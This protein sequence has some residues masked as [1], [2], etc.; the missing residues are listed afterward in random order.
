VTT[1]AIDNSVALLRFLLTRDMDAYHRLAAEQDPREHRTYAALLTTA[2][3]QATAKRFAQDS[4]SAAIIEFVSEARA[5]IVGP[6]A[7]VPEDAERVIRAALG[8]SDLIDDMDGKAYGRAQVAVLLAI[9]HEN[10]DAPKEIDALL[11]SAADE[12]AEYF[13][14]REA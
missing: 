12:T 13:R 10:D 7:M 2:F 8:E 6:E 1:P 14:R 4:S 3:Y 5:R 11:S 9:T